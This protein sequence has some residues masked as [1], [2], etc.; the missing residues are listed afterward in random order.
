MNEEKFKPFIFD[1][2]I[3]YRKESDHTIKP[4]QSY[5]R[6]YTERIEKGWLT[7]PKGVKKFN[8]DWYLSETG[9]MWHVTDYTIEKER[10]EEDDWILHLMTKGW[11]DANTFLPA[12]FEALKRA[13]INE[14]TIIPRY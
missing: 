6:E 14:V 10:L 5:I 9:D 11:F 12:Y 4:S 3:D 1:D 2:T 8:K 13:K 7:V